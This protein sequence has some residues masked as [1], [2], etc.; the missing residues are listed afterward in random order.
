MEAEKLKKEFGEQLTFWGGGA[1]TQHILPFRKQEE[2]V[3]HVKKLIK[4]FAPRG[5]YVYAPVHNIQPNTPPENIAAMFRTA[6]NHGKYPIL[7]I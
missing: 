6:Y 1:D 4:I 7:D 3:E 5:G 2:T